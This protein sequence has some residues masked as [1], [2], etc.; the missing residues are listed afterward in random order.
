MSKITILFMNVNRGPYEFGLFSGGSLK[1]WISN[2]IAIAILIL[3][4]FSTF[5][6]FIF[7]KKFK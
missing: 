6:T 5:L 2:G 3:T 1:E 7:S 4:I